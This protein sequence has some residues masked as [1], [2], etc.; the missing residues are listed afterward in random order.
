YKNY[1]LSTI[2]DEKGKPTRSV[3][4]AAKLRVTK[5]LFDDVPGS[6][7]A[8]SVHISNPPPG[9]I[10]SALQPTT[11]H[12][13][14]ALL[15]RKWCPRVPYRL[16]YKEVCTSLN[17]VTDFR[18]AVET[19]SDGVTALQLL[20]LAGWVHR[21]ISSGNLLRYTELEDGPKC[22]LGD[23]EFMKEFQHDEESGSDPK[24]GTPFFMALEIHSG[25]PLIRRPWRGPRIDIRKL[26]K[27]APLTD[28]LLKEAIPSQETLRLYEIKHN[29]EHDLESIF[30]LLLWFL[31]SRSTHRP[32]QEYG[33]KVFQHGLAPSSSRRLIF[34]APEVTV[35]TIA[36]A[37]SHLPSGVF[38]GVTYF[39]DILYSG[40]ADRDGRFKDKTTYSCLYTEARL[41]LEAC[42]K[43]ADEVEVEALPKPLPGTENP[44]VSRHQKRKAPISDDSAHAPCQMKS[45]LRS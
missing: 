15:E 36:D 27:S 5:D 18:E 20:F 21:D 39:R 35:S 33:R 1:F 23:L 19:L 37:L 14:D 6:S 34:E 9:Q 26:A 16:V 17:D 30:W 42:M 11:A 29:Y 25:V 7:W 38:L 44:Q 43:V 10:A 24:T 31:T 3:P 13:P 2:V 4:A 28:Q 41:S 32:A 40:Y 22:R 12:E 45:L 8:A